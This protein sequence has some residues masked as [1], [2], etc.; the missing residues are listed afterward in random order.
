MEE[1]FLEA[2]TCPSPCGLLSRLHLGA[3]SCSHPSCHLGHLVRLG[4]VWRPRDEGSAASNADRS[5]QARG[6]PLSK[7]CSL[8]I[9][10]SH[11]PETRGH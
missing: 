6:L 11:P 5:G 9:S 7:P 4:V 2:D 10:A 3:S 1:T 8:C